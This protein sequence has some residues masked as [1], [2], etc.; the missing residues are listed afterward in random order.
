MR[1]GTYVLGIVD[2]SEFPRVYLATYWNEQLSICLSVKK[3]GRENI[4]GIFKLKKWK[5]T[6]EP[7]Y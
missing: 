4:I 5:D 6:F 1:D 2:S 7:A 3:G